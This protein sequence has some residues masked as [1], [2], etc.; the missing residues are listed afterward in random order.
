MTYRIFTASLGAICTLAFGQAAFAASQGKVSQTRDRAALF[1]QLD[2]DGNGVLTQEELAKAGQLR[3]AKAD[4]DKD[5]FLSKA[6]VRNQMLRSLQK[7]IA[8][9]SAKMVERRDIDKDGKLSLEE[10]QATS[11]KRGTKIFARLDKNDDG[12]VSA[13]EFEKMRRPGG[14]IHS[15]G[16][17]N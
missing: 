13:E 7:R 11:G 17:L 4:S 15:G 10:M 3:F 16:S 8:G 1:T 12:A 5:G 2:V 14:K 6:E 9:K